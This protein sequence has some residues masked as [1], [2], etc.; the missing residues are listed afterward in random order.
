MTGKQ[1]YARLCR[2]FPDF[3]DWMEKYTEVRE[4]MHSLGIKTY[5]MNM[6]RKEAT[7][8]LKEVQCLA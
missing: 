6:S 2:D 7:L 8:V 4:A 1:L 5:V 3:Y